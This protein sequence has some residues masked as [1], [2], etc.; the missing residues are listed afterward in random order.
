MGR[1]E[2][3]D[4]RRRDDVPDV[5]GKSEVT[6]PRNLRDPTGVVHVMHVPRATSSDWTVC[7]HAANDQRWFSVELRL[8]CAFPTCLWCV[9]VAS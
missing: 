5:F 2:T 3:R 4:E 1:T 7:E 6:Q 8:T 9:G